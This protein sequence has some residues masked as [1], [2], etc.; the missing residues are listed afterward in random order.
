MVSLPSGAAAARKRFKTI[1]NGYR[2]MRRLSCSSTMTRQAVRRRRKRQASYHLASARS[3]RL[4][5]DYKDASDALSAGDSQ[6]VRE[7]IWDAR[8]Y[9]PDGI[10]DGK[11][12]LELVTTPSPPCRS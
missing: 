3:L 10:V 1:W 11:T 5:G 9:R 8:P 6:A 2:A 4:T 7:A 12:L